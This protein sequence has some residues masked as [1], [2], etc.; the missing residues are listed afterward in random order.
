MMKM[1]C[2]FCKENYCMFCEPEH[3]K[4][5]DAMAYMELTK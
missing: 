3:S 1:K 5:C 4:I 2:W